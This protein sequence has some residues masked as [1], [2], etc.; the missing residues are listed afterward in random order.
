[1]ES[2]AEILKRRRMQAGIT[3]GTMGRS[4]SRDREIGS[5]FLGIAE[6]SDCPLCGGVGFVHPKHASGDPDYGRVV[7]CSCAKRHLENLR[8]ERLRE[9]SHLGPLTSYIFNS[10]IQTGRSIAPSN[11]ALFQRAYQDARIYAERPE[12]WLVF[13]GPSGCGKT[14]LAAAIANRCIELGVPVLFVAVPDLLDQ[15]RAGYGQDSEVPFDLM[16]EQVR[17][18]ALLIV[19]DLGSHISTPWAQEKLLQIINYRFYLSLPTVFTI[20][21]PLAEMPERI[22]SRLTDTSISNICMLEEKPGFN[23]IGEGSLGLLKDMTF[24]N[25][26]SNISPI[27]G[28]REDQE[29]AERQTKSLD[30]AHSAALHYAQDAQ[31]WLVLIG[32]VGSGKTH[33]AASIANHHYKHGQPAIFVVV[34]DLLDHLRATYGPDS[35]TTFD[36][37]FEGLKQCPLL[38]LD[39]FGAQTSSSWA[40]EK[41]FQLINHRHNGRLPTVITTN[42]SLDQIARETDHRIVSRLLDSRMCDVLV[43]DATDYRQSP[44]SRQVG[45]TE[46]KPQGQRGRSAGNS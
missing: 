21:G 36:R 29:I 6:H 25:F 3:K 43:I 7:E 31:G 33:L 45:R 26:I 2:L 32:P 13:T 10:L 37:T 39:D 40:K 24:D 18:A 19:D 14:H 44:G 17:N 5:P 27:S 20:N 23:S 34:P 1:M 41:L 22:H 46:S 9:Y 11:K 38:I 28:G 15:L 8:P 42:L 35:G 16:L 30:S 12:G 4:S